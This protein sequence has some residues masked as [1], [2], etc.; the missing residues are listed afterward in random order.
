MYM[1][2]TYEYL[3][4][5]QYLER[6]QHNRREWVESRNFYWV[7]SG[8]QACSVW[9]VKGLLSSVVQAEVRLFAVQGVQY[10]YLYLSIEFNDTSFHAAG[11]QCYSTCTVIPPWSPRNLPPNCALG[12]LKNI[13][14]GNTHHHRL[15]YSKAQLKSYI[16]I[17]FISYISEV[18]CIAI[19]RICRSIV[20]V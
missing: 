7:T 20:V 2:C 15:F 19:N 17:E 12:L 13:N 3:L 9:D 11:K 1:Y 8:N 6:C 10:K 16:H 14:N 5:V 4:T 18:C